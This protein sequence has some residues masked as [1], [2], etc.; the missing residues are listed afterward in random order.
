MTFAVTRS[1]TA[2]EN[3]PA[4]NFDERVKNL[5]AHGEFSLRTPARH[6]RACATCSN[7]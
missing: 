5:C 6:P 3:A 7:D 2:Y 4:G 1:P